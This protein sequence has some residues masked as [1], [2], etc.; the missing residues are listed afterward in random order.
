MADDSKKGQTRVRVGYPIGAFEHH[1][2]GVA[3]PLT[4]EW[5]KEPLS[6]SKLRELRKVAKANDVPLE[7]TSAEVGSARGEGDA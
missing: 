1:V 4:G 7:E 2:S 6:D 5:T 3:D